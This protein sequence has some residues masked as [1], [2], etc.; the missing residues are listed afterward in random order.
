MVWALTT[1]FYSDSQ[2]IPSVHLQCVLFLYQSVAICP[3]ISL[4]LHYTFY[5]IC[6]SLLMIPV[7]GG[8]LIVQFVFRICVV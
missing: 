5:L 6:F 8:L 7:L 3:T 4:V 1:D 2:L